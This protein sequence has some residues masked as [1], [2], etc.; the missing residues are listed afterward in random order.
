MQRWE[1]VRLFPLATTSSYQLWPAIGYDDL[2]VEINRH[3]DR[4]SSSEK[5]LGPWRQ[6]KFE[7]VVKLLAALGADGWEAV[8]CDRVSEVEPHILFKRPIVDG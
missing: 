3:P 6:N 4:A 1:Y 7:H 8:S 5:V 2:L